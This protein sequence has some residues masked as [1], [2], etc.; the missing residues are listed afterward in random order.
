MAEPVKRGDKYRHSI[1]VDGVRMTGTFDTKKDAR[2]WE[3]EQRALS[4]STPG[5]PGELVKKKHTLSAA[6]EKYL[7]SVTPTKRDAVDWETRRFNAF[8]ARFPGRYLED[9]TS[10]DVAQWRDD[11][12]A[13]VS[14]ST[15]NRY[16]NLYS[17]LFTVAKREWKWVKENPFSEVKRPRENPPREAVWRWH[18]IR[19]VLRAGQR[20]GGKTGEVVKA[21]HVALATSLRLQ[22]ALVAP[23]V[24][25]DTS[26]TITLPPNKSSHWKPEVV[27]TTARARRIIKRYHGKAFAVG[28]N[29][30]STLFCNLCKQL[31]I[32]GLQFKDARATALTLMSRRMDVLT[33]AKFS[34]HKDLELL[35]STYYRESLEDISRRT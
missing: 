20:R 23:K 31:L 33:L 1:Q 30:A 9:I 34:R 15:I 18:E 29:E 11:M 24:Y 14:G 7:S 5:S 12:L 28:P 13:T 22:E 25:S 21:F 17:N 27:P 3:A 6:C 19:R 4:S 26:L 16:W 32:E 10:A 8:I 2:T 35:R